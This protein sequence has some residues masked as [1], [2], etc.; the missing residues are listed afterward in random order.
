MK[1]KIVR[2]LTY[3]Y[4]DR[5][6]LISAL[7]SRSVNGCREFWPLGRITERFVKPGDAVS[8]EVF[9][10]LFPAPLDKEP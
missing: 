2:V 5:D 6:S 3:A 4:N 7:K 9:D 10:E 8:Q 1:Y